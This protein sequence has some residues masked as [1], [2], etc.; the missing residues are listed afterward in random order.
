MVYGCNSAEHSFNLDSTV[1]EVALKYT[2]NYCAIVVQKTSTTN[3][4][5]R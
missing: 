2:R 3:P 1:Q 4:Q 5:V